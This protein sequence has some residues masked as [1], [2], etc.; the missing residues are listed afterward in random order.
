MLKALS[1]AATLALTALTAGAQTMDAVVSQ[2]LA[3]DPVLTAERMRLQRLEAEIHAENTLR[4]PEVGMSYR[5]GLD[6]VGNK[7]DLEVAQEFDWPGLYRARSRQASMQAGAF[8]TLYRAKEVEQALVVRQAIYTLLSAHA[9]MDELS[10]WEQNLQ[11]LV[12]VYERQLKR[13][14]TTILEVSKLKLEIFRARTRIAEAQ[15]RLAAAEAD[16]KALNGGEMPAQLPHTASCEPLQPFEYY[17]DAIRAT[18][19]QVAA[20][21][22]LFDLAQQQARVDKLKA[23][24]GFKLGYVYENEAGEHFHGFSFAVTLPTWN[25]RAASRASEAALIETMA[26]ADV[27]EMQRMAQ[28]QALYTAARRA[29][30]LMTD[31]EALFGDHSDYLAILRKALDGGKITLLEFIREENDYLEGALEYTALCL[32]F[33]LAASSLNRADFAAHD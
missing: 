25:R 9:E 1:L 33:N 3:N 20:S 23:A 10:H 4:G 22:R 27:V 5:W 18:D 14:E 8:A 2:V 29:H 13:G 7:W 6:G 32:E 19:P 30:Q 28:V 21:R 24:P 11:E 12:E 16:L 17:R 26:Q 31:G 15:N